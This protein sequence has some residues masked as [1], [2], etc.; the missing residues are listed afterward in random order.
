MGIRAAAAALFNFKQS[1]TVAGMLS[2]YNTGLARWTSGGYERMAKNAYSKNTAA[3]RAIKMVADAAAAVPLEIHKKES[4]KL[5]TLPSHKAQKLLDNPNPNESGPEHRAALFSH[6]LLSGNFYIEGVGPDNAPPR[7]LYSHR[8]DRMRIIPGQFG[9]AGYQYQVNGQ[10]K[11]WPV[12]PITG[13]GDILHAKTFNPLDDF[14]GMGPL[15]AAS[16]SVDTNN[17][18]VDWNK[19]LLDNGGRPSGALIWKPKEDRKMGDDTYNRLQSQLEEKHM[20]AKNAG[21]PMILENLEWQEMSFSPKDMDYLENKNTSARDI[22]NAFGVPPQLGGIPGDN[23]YSNM[24]E[25][26]L[27][28]YE[29]TALP[30]LNLYC[31]A[32]SGWL[33]YYY[34]ED[35]IVYYDE[36]Q[37][38]ALE[39]R[40]KEKWD[41][42][43]NAGFLTINEQR[44]A[45]GYA[46]VKNGDTIYIG[47]GQLP[48][49]Y[50]PEPVEDKPPGK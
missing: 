3:F 44:E 45:V 32:L 30:L 33:S 11:V 14:Y 23:T 4:G 34:G 16:R 37:I 35:I 20:G 26:R 13:R 43:Q 7:E 18:V 49:D 8:P 25:A 12:D 10:T 29:E 1:P 50:E 28:L 41:K 17:A 40:R 46:A 19:A 21:R 22:Y 15:E 2:L 27:A 9:V 38:S 31:R 5:V 48:I 24:K 36:D 6:F 39:P 42:I 47:A